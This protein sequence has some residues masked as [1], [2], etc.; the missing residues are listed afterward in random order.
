MWSQPLQNRQKA[1]SAGKSFWEAKTILTRKSR[2]EALWLL[3]EDAQGS[4]L[5]R[6]RKERKLERYEG[7]LGLPLTFSHS[8]VLF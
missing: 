2:K 8:L 6:K 5:Q 3:E 4:S 1:A 7:E